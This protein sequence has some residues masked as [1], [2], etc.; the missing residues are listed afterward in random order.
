M[1]ISNNHAINNGGGIY[2]DAS[3]P[4]IIGNTIKDNIAANG[5]GIYLNNGSEPQIVNNHIGILIGAVV[6]G[7]IASEN[8]GGI[9]CNNSD[10]EIVGNFIDYNSANNS[11]PAIFNQGGGLFINSSAP[12]IHD[13][14][15]ITNNT[16]KNDGGGIFIDNSSPIIEHNSFI[17]NNSATNRYGGGIYCNNS[18]ATRIELNTINNNN[19]VY[20]GG[21]YVDNVISSTQQILNNLIVA[22][23]ANNGAGIYIG[24]FINPPTSLIVNSNTIADNIASIEGGGIFCPSSGFK[25]LFKNDIIWG[26]TAPIGP[27][28][29]TGYIQNNYSMF[30]FCDIQFSPGIYP[31]LNSNPMFHGGGNYHLH[32]FPTLSPCIDAGLN[33]AEMTLNDLDLTNRIQFNIIDMGC[34]EH[35]RVNWLI[36]LNDIETQNND[37]NNDGINDIVSLKIYPNP[38]TEFTIFNF[39][40]SEQSSVSIS[41]YDIQ[42]KIIF[43]LND[44]L[45]LGSSNIFWYPENL[46][47]GIYVSNIKINNKIFVKK[48]IIK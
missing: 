42:G 28:V 15:S 44:L 48:L 20:G 25:G 38:L 17:S 23:R 6:H 21:I 13:N 8:G 19:A 27:S 11:N 46:S 32:Y 24:N 39:N 2:C 29:S 45:S 5:A 31:N 4:N 18:P 33:L 1:T 9:Y 35:D 16:A 34:Y 10:P 12:Y 37:E 22:N 43:N 40:L 26:N 7:N 14:N 47:K 3:N 41:I 36:F 30:Y